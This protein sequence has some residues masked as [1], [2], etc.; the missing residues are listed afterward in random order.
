MTRQSQST[1]RWTQRASTRDQQQQS[2][3]VF[4]FDGNFRTWEQVERRVLIN[5]A[6]VA[7]AAR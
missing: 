2:P 7:L 6:F 3:P 4:F 1:H 5:R